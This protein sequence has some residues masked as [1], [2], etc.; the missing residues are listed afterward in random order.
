M[1]LI[2]FSQPKDTASSKRCLNSFFVSETI[3]RAF[4]YISLFKFH[5]CD[6]DNYY[7]RPR[8]TNEETEDWRDK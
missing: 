6:V 8:F 7:Y 4:S 2:R 1:Q 3:P 5:P